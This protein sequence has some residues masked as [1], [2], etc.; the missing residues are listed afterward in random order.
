M[1]K[2]VES[3]LTSRVDELLMEGRKLITYL[4]EGGLQWQVPLKQL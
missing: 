2:E 3:L 4:W 1:K